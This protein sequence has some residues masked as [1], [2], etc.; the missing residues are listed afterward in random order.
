MLFTLLYKNK[1]NVFGL[2][3]NPKLNPNNDDTK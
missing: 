1:K 2:G 3:E